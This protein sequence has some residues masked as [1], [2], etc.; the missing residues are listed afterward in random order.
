M[1]NVCGPSRSTEPLPRCVCPALSSTGPVS[2]AARTVVASTCFDSEGQG[3]EAAGVSR[4]ADADRIGA[5]QKKLTALR[6]E[7]LTD[8]WPS[9]RDQ[10]WRDRNAVP[11]ERQLTRLF[12]LNRNW[13]F[14]EVVPFFVEFGE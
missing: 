11:P 13:V 4:A 1:C 12:Q 2:D 5:V 6:D 14:A 10:G 7:L 3:D 8:Q 9:C